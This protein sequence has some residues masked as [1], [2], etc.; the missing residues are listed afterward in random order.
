VKRIN[1]KK[2]SENEKEKNEETESDEKEKVINKPL[3]DKR[4]SK[5]STD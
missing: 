3:T 2:K 4:K 1:K 5:K